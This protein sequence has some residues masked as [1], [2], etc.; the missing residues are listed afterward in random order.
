MAG[1]GQDA[2]GKE[3][4]EDKSS[5]GSGGGGGGGGG[6]PQTCDPNPL[7]NPPFFVFCIVLQVLMPLVSGFAEIGESLSSPASVVGTG[8]VLVTGSDAALYLRSGRDVPT[9]VQSHLQAQQEIH[10]PVTWA[11]DAQRLPRRPWEQEAFVEALAELWESDSDS[12]VTVDCHSADEDQVC[13]AHYCVARRLSKGAIGRKRGGPSL[14]S[15]I[16][17]ARRVSSPVRALHM[18]PGAAAR[19]RE[20]TPRIE[21]RGKRK[22]RKWPS[23][24]WAAASGR[25]Q[26]VGELHG[27]RNARESGKK[28]PAARGEAVSEGPEFLEEGLRSQVHADARAPNKFKKANLDA[29][30]VDKDPWAM[31]QI[32]GHS[33]VPI[34]S[35]RGVLTF[36][37]VV[38]AMNTKESG[39]VQYIDDAFY[40]RVGWN[41]EG[42]ATR[43]T[44]YLWLPADIPG[45]RPS[46][47]AHHGAVLAPH[48]LGAH[49]VQSMVVFGGYNGDFMT[50]YKNDLWAVTDVE[51]SA[52]E[53]ATEQL[54]V[55][56]D[57]IK[58]MEPKDVHTK[59]SPMPWDRNPWYSTLW[60]KGWRY[61]PQWKQLSPSGMPP[62]PRF[63]MGLAAVSH[64]AVVFGGYGIDGFTN[65]LHAV[66]LRR[67][68]WL[69]MGHYREAQFSNHGWRVRGEPPAPRAGHSA[70]TVG[71]YVVFYGG[72][73]AEGG[74][75]GDVH[76]L[77]I[78]CD[79]D[80]QTRLPRCSNSERLQFTWRP[81]RLGDP[82]PVPRWGHSAVLTEGGYFLAIVGGFQSGGERE[83]WRKHK[84]LQGYSNSFQLLDLRRPRV[85][86]I[87]PNRADTHGAREMLPD[88]DLFKRGPS[89]PFPS[90]W[91]LV[92]PP[93]PLKAS[94]AMTRV[95]AV[96]PPR[97]VKG[98]QHPV[99]SMLYEE[100]LYR[101]IRVRVEGKALG[102]CS[103]FVVIDGVKR[104]NATCTRETCNEWVWHSNNNVTV[105]VAGEPCRN[106]TWYSESHLECFLT[107][108]VG[109]DADVIVDAHGMA[110]P[111]GNGLFHF[112]PPRVDDI[113]PNFLLDFN[114]VPR[115]PFII[116]GKNFGASPSPIEIYIRG[117]VCLQSLWLSDNA[118]AC[119]CL[120]KAADKKGPRGMFSKQTPL[121]KFGREGVVV[122]VGNQW[123]NM[124]SNFFLVAPPPGLAALLLVR[125]KGFRARCPPL[126]IVEELKDVVESPDLRERAKR[127]RR[128]FE[129][130][131]K[132]LHQMR[133]EHFNTNLKELTAIVGWM[134]INAAGAMAALAAAAAMATG[135]VG[136]VL[137]QLLL[138]LFTPK[139]G[140]AALLSERVDISLW[141]HSAGGSRVGGDD[142]QVEGDEG[143]GSRGGG[144]LGVEE[145]S[146]RHH[147][148]GDG[149]CRIVLDGT[150]AS[151][152]GNGT[153]EAER[154]ISHACGCQRVVKEA[155]IH[156][157]IR[158]RDISSKCSRH[159]RHYA[160]AK[161]C[162]ELQQ[163][164]FQ[165]CGGS[166]ASRLVLGLSPVFTQCE[167]LARVLQRTCGSHID[168]G[169]TTHT[170]AL[171]E[172]DEA[173]EGLALV[174]EFKT[175]RAE[176]QAKLRQ[177]MRH[178]HGL[179]DLIR[180][181]D[182]RTGARLR[183]LI[184]AKPD[185][186][187]REVLQE[188]SRA[189]AEVAE[190]EAVQSG[191]SLWGV[192]AGGTSSEDDTSL[193]GMMRGLQ[194]IAEVISEPLGDAMARSRVLMQSGVLPQTLRPSAWLSKL[195]FRGVRT[196][197][198]PQ[199]VPGSEDEGTPHD[200][201]ETPQKTGSG[202]GVGHEG[203]WREGSVWE[204][205]AAPLP[206]A[207]LPPSVA[208]PLGKPPHP[209]RGHSATLLADG[210]TMLVY[211]GFGL[212]RSYSDDRDA[213]AEYANATLMN[214]VGK[215]VTF[216]DTYLLQSIYGRPEREFRELMITRTSCTRDSRYDMSTDTMDGGQPRNQDEHPGTQTLYTD[217]QFSDDD[218]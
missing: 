45:P 2:N 187:A 201:V 189:H 15:L 79:V 41:P 152:Q 182:R 173:R 115:G 110:N 8:G 33:A 84:N 5:G 62:S 137:K 198:R 66:D 114:G 196:L 154:S 127:K 145:W 162:K 147:A 105:T 140:D 218:E 28:E 14:D 6:A 77:S 174:E 39:D 141:V 98:T 4:E 17:V 205:K 64:I 107:G 32:A 138:S 21:G 206:M 112:N 104:C 143:D 158:Q 86:K 179:K 50:G 23:P 181:G 130:E 136:E 159:L 1:L 184:A 54:S 150:D 195:R 35:G 151:V 90:P 111:P 113:T 149:K 153:F 142:E 120:S 212:A 51:Q 22:A 95:A 129:E 65:D 96:M 118:V 52:E 87:T 92:S 197:L 144:G 109:K 103:E 37:G 160:V 146:D 148:P 131:L 135:T 57:L 164:F 155:Q 47:R 56:P 121:K 199:R 63:R 119:V 36:G 9:C 214:F 166:N 26:A 128:V 16:E 27:D 203:K 48:L 101:P 123:S 78:G 207:F 49:G 125:G 74:L 91:F 134:Q 108:G 72:Y 93:A 100:H 24:W 38:E 157:V 75:F 170:L 67:M 10:L 106:L 193:E 42:N 210:R 211:G 94:I 167:L 18:D 188:A 40:C 163:S 217:N 53:Q 168:G 194:R 20:Y 70:T 82:F 169:S 80:R 183:R 44:G 190:A 99:G 19:E 209:R 73:S 25:D 213:E 191:R 102:S 180:R 29:L 30:K 175:F 76:V 177:H 116:R 71:T 13:G 192:A 204:G 3:D 215:F 178:L 46:A 58:P 34:D 186:G 31:P 83:S 12:H 176:T 133:E 165:S 88:S 60:L 185:L 7:T 124:Y 126:S 68:Q 202:E 156:G 89:P 59:R 216:N 43:G 139:G 55:K 117:E 208:C 85:T 161:G 172:T 132:A 69:D 122:K 81:V 171:L 11:R 200:V 97:S 61:K